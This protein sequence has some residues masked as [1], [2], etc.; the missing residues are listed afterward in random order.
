MC[1]FISGFS[2][3]FHQSIFLFLCQYCCG[4]KNA[5]C[6]FS[7]LKFV[8]ACFVAQYL[9]YPGELSC[10]HLERMC[11]LLF[12]DIVI[13]I[14]LSGTTGLLCHLRPLL[15]YWFSVWMFCPFMQ[16]RV[17]S[18]YYY[19]IILHFSLYVCQYLFYILA[20]PIL[21]TCILTTYWLETY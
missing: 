19:C 7:P 18:P 21:G 11:V 2:I 20:S 8:E 4:Q 15:P 10:V 16:W 1:G 13:C 9:I 3:L 5:W 14:Y 12:L 17:K 6:N